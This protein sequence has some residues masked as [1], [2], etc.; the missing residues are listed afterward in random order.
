MA[1][2]GAAPGHRP[3]R[4]PPRPAT[5]AQ[6]RSGPAT[7]PPPRRRAARA[8][9]GQ[10]ARAPDDGSA[11]TTPHRQLAVRRPD[12][13][14]VERPAGED[15][16]AAHRRGGRTAARP[17]RRH[18]PRR[19]A[20]RLPPAV[21]AAQPL[22]RRHQQPARRAQHLPRRHRQRPR[23][24]ARHAVRHRR[25]GQRRGRQV[26][27]RPAPPGP[28]GPLAG[29]PARRAGHHRR[30]PLP[31]RRTPPPR[32][33]VPQGLPGV[34]RPPGADPLRRGREVRQGGGHRAR[35]LAP[36]LRHRA[37]RAADRAP[38]RHPHRRGPQRPPAGPARQGRPHPAGPRRLLRLLG[39]RGRPH[40]GHRALVPRPV[41]QAARDGLPGPVLV[42]PQVHPGLRGRGAG[43]RPHDVAHH[44]PAQP[45]TERG[46]Q[47]R[48]RHPRPAQGPGPQGAAAV[49][50]EAGDPADRN[51]VIPART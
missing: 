2:P 7:A 26:H 42:L 38:A 6:V 28:A 3:Y 40:R 34:L 41:P 15:P 31:Q 45:G 12:P 30:L 44:Q 47:P 24:P 29:A 23:R 37:R 35:L 33:D 11:A 10:W 46:P 20:R 32:P 14:G 36:D 13:R 50:A 22:R 8:G 48:P 21:P 51:S 16:A 39:L 19:S 17:G 18:R 25:R 43:V 27:H 49:A 9:P 5:N 4:A 1:L